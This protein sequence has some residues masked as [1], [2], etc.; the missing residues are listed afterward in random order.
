MKGGMNGD[1]PGI[2]FEQGGVGDEMGAFV[3]DFDEIRKGSKLIQR[4]LK[5][6]IHQAAG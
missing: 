1:V 5:R 6:F 4:L 2:T 3:H